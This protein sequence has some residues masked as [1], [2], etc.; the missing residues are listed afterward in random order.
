MKK[1]IVFIIALF[2]GLTGFNGES[3]IIEQNSVNFQER[4]AL[5]GYAPQIVRPLKDL[6]AP[7]GSS[8]TFFATVSSSDCLA[9]WYKNGEI[10]PVGGRFQFYMKKNTAKLT[11]VDVFPEDA[12][13]YVVKFQN[14]YGEAISTAR[15]FVELSR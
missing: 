6:I 4:V 15:L 12:G 1:R 13:V 3:R 14:R 5:V 7:E 11:I 8:I 2:L 10:L 9:V